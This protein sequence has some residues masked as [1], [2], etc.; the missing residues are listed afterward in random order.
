MTNKGGFILFRKGGGTVDVHPENRDLGELGMRQLFDEESKS[1]SYLI[2]DKETEEAVLVDPVK[3]QVSRDIL[4]STNLHL[5]Y[6]INTHVHED[7]CS[8]TGLL[9]KKVK[10]LKSIISKASH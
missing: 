10:G 6:A 9:K 4:V 8:G 2:W 1:F 7:R 3:G 5:V